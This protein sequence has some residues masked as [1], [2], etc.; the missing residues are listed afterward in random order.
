MPPQPVGVRRYETTLP[1]QYSILSLL[2]QALFSWPCFGLFSNIRGRALFSGFRAK[3]ALP[4]MFVAMQH[5]IE[6]TIS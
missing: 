5:N 4:A 3:C 2:C 6:K 1:K